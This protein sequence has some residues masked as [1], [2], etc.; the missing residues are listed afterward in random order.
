M[1]KLRN[2]AVASSAAAIAM[3]VAC[4][5][6]RPPPLGNLSRPSGLVYVDRGR[7]PSEGEMRA[8]VYIA[9]SLAEGVRGLMFDRI[10]AGTS[11]SEDFRYIPAPVVYFPLVIPAEG[12]PTRLALSRTSTTYLYALAPAASRLYVIEAK[13]LPFSTNIGPHDVQS[14]DLIGEIP[15]D[16]IFTAPAIATAVQTAPFDAN[17]DLLLVAFDLIGAERGALAA[18]E[19]G[20]ETGSD[21]T[22][23]A[24][25]ASMPETLAIEP[26][27]RDIVIRDDG[28]ALMSSTSSRSIGFSAVRISASKPHLPVRGE[29]ID[30]GGPTI[31]VIDAK[32]RGIVALRQD[33]PAAVLFDVVTSSQA[34]GIVRSNR[35]IDSPYTPED[36]RA[37]I[38]RDRLG[39]IDLP[40][41]PLASGAYGR[42]RAIF[43]VP[44]MPTQAATGLYLTSLFTADDLSEG[45]PGLCARMGQKCGDVVE[46]TQLNGRAALLI[47]NPL[48]LATS[49]P[50]IVSSMAIE[51]SARLKQGMETIA[52]DVEIR[53]CSNVSAPICTLPEST[54]TTVPTCADPFRINYGVATSDTLRVMY[55]GRLANSRF[56]TLTRRSAQDQGSDRHF[57]LDDGT[58]GN[59]LAVDGFTKRL[60]RHD[61]NVLVQL[62][63]ACD[64]ARF[65]CP[66]DGAPIQAQVEGRVERVVSDT[67][68]EVAFT[69]TTMSS[70]P[71]VWPFDEKQ[72][73][74]VATYEVYPHDGEVV[75]SVVSGVLSER[76]LA[77]TATSSDAGKMIATFDEGRVGFTLATTSSGASFFCRNEV[78]PKNEATDLFQSTAC[79]IDTDC[80]SSTICTPSS[81]VKGLGIKGCLGFC[82]FPCDDASLGCV[83]GEIARR[84]TSVTF[85]VTAV[86][87]TN[88]TFQVMNGVLPAAPDQSVFS[89]IHESFIVS[90]PGSRGLGLIRVDPA[91]GF[92]A[93]QIR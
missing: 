25:L 34:I 78:A 7:G 41:S 62:R 67:E 86:N 53:G 52:S 10:L 77:R 79:H 65:A 69:T 9:D 20:F 89:P 80:P 83:A 16:N 58:L 27:P 40:P 3:T 91:A 24:R 18:F 81:G 22:V 26:A 28:V 19:V 56:A 70:F 76:V 13:A 49:A 59:G 21:R 43:D 54:V 32:A 61:D 68:L 42:L 23:E 35:R 55:R 36:E 50:P 38:S 85:A 45:G 51:E 17:H 84:C 12:F 47:G 74:P 60:I 31:G 33:R 48:R 73:V 66:P 30:A 88:P 57:L 15:L 11:T 63:F 2:I 5:P 87:A 72:P 4:S 37:T 29:R 14:N 64:Q 90:F 75:L 46:I 82:T 1:T 93:Q 6:D 8:D 92:V 44:L 71:V 39:R